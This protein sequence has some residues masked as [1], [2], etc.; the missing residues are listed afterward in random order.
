MPSWLNAP[1]NY[2]GLAA[3]NPSSQRFFFLQWK[4]AFA[5]YL[6][7]S[8]MMF[9]VA[10][11]VKITDDDCYKSL[12]PETAT[13]MSCSSKGLTGTSSFLISCV[14]VLMR[15]ASRTQC[16]KLTTIF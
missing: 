13:V 4:C 14:P 15:F 6:L 3:T 10:T 11:A 5:I 16:G 12:D 1:M 8:A 9:G 2:P 7:F